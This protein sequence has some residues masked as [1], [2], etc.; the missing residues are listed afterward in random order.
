MTKDQ[1]YQAKLIEKRL[2]NLRETDN[3]ASSFFEDEIQNDIPELQSF[4]KK[5]YLEFK[6]AC[7]EAEDRL[8]EEFTKL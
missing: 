2:S 1:L 8:W 7:K 5:S 3:T 6:Q 4:F